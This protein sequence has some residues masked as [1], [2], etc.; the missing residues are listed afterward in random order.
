MAQP[1]TLTWFARHELGLAWRDWLSMMTAGKKGRELVLVV[2][3]GVIAVIAHALAGSIVHS[4]A[5]EG[6]ELNKANLLLLAGGSLLFF[7]LM[8][9]QAMESVTRAYYARSDLDLILSSPA[10]SRR[11]FAVR[12]AAIAASTMS[13][14]GLIAAPLINM[15]AWYDGPQWLSAYLVM[16]CFGALATGISVVAVLALFRTLG[17]KRTRLISQIVAAVVGAGFIIGIQ[18]AAIFYYGSISR[19]ALFQSPELIA[20]APD[21]DHLLWLPAKAAMGDPFALGLLAIASFGFL[22]LVISTSS[23]SFGHHAVAAAGVSETR[24]V[25]APRNETFRPGTPRQALRRKEWTLLKRDP[26]LVSQTLMQILY[27]LPPA[28]M[29]WLYY[30][31]NSGVMVV[32]IPVLVMASGQLAG[33]LAWLAISGEDAPDLVATAPVSPRALVWAKVEA[34]MTVM[35]VVVAPFILGMA[36]A[37]LQTAVLAAAFIALSAGSATAIQLWF[38]VQAKRTM[39]RR[40]QVSSRT[41]TFAEAFAS[42]MWAGTSGLAAA[43]SWFALAPAILALCVLAAARAIAPKEA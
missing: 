35:A 27:L 8:L 21:V 41:A 2:V 1:T 18:A 36:L 5:A 37:S 39:F 22:A 16:I 7:T 3:L 13:L 10:S 28:L 38:R 17:P 40:R 9:S 30:G 4:W 19:M 31:E 14:S 24:Q 33:G 20:A 25:Q 29:L 42:I 26:W 15:L 11:L 12:T 34:V 32:I 23:A 6:V 43:G